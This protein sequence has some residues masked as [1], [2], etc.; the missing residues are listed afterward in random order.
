MTMFLIYKF[1]R[2]VSCLKNTRSPGIEFIE[3]RLFSMSIK[4]Y[5]EMKIYR[6]VYKSST[7]NK[8]Y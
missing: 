8:N 4:M 7:S 3:F 1:D 2:S 5:I 6:M